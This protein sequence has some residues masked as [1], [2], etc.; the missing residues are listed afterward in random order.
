MFIAG[1]IQLK[2]EFRGRKRITAKY[3]NHKKDIEKIIENYKI[4]DSH[5]KTETLS[6]ALNPNTIINELILNYNY[7]SKFA[8]YNTIVNLLYEMSYKYHKTP[9]SK[10]IDKGP[11]TN[12][13]SKNND[14]FT[15]YAY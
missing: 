14:E 15:R 9:K 8:C 5:F 6:I 4:I 3:T 2:I 12:E 7:P 11:E 1:C 10:V 13:M